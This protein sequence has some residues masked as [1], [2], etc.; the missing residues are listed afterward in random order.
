MVVIPA[1][2]LYQKRVV[3]MVKGNKSETIFYDYKPLELV[4]K[5]LSSGFKLIHVVDLSKTIDDSTD[6]FDI[7]KDFAKNDYCEYIQIGG[8]IRNLN[9]ALKLRELGF[10]RQI[11]TSAIVRDQNILLE[12]LDNGID[13]VFG[14]DTH[15][16][17]EMAISGW[18][19]Y[20]KLDIFEFLNLLKKLGL[21][22]IVHTDNSVDG[23]MEGR[24]L[25]LTVEIIKRTNLQTIVAG[26]IASIEDLKRIEETSKEYPLLKGAIVG[27]AFYEGTVT[28]EEMIEHAG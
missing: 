27:R 26:G 17:N 2:D 19:T 28:L 8:G 22:E 23:T 9:Y 6:N 16:K 18:K 25:S 10:Q 12:L 24:D 4:E 11:I 14:L 21:K 7:L 1:I 5:F 13:V 3:R 15:R 20:E